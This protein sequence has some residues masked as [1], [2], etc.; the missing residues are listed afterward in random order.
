MEGSFGRVCFA[1]SPGSEI[2]VSLDDLPEATRKRLLE[3]GQQNSE[4]MNDDLFEDCPF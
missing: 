3:I 4:A 2:W 1:R